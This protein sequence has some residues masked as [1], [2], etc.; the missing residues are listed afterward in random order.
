MLYLANWG[1]RHLAF[2]FPKGL[3][4]LE[5]LQQ[6]YW[7][8]DEITLKTT[9]H[10]V[11]LAIQFDDEGGGEWIE[12]DG[13]LSTLTP[14]REDILRGDLRALHLAY[15]KAAQYAEEID[16]EDLDDGLEDD[17]EEGAGD[18][19]AVEVPVPPGLDLLTAPLRAFVDF[20][21]IDADLI[22]RAAVASPPLESIDDDVERRIA[23][24]PDAERAV[25][26]VRLARGEPH[27]SIQ[28]LRRLREVGVRTES[29]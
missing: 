14:L 15:L 7:A 12:G 6:Y 1:T 10:H 27:L 5:R 4:D 25:W 22:T 18:G 3:L 20:F 17:D 26:L 24:L 2:R 13:L 21:E 16:D 19:V 23:L 9:E 11:V 28:L 8:A 29:P